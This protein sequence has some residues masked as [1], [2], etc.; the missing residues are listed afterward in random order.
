MPRKPK[1]EMTE[2]ELEALRTYYRE[3]QRKRKESLS[4]EEL[5]KKKEIVKQRNKEY[6]EKNNEVLKEKRKKYIAENKDKI[7]QDFKEWYNKN[8][9][10]RKEYAL[11]YR[12][13]NKEKINTDKK[14][15]RSTD[16]LYKLSENIRNLIRKAIKRKN[17]KK[18]SK[19]IDILGC[20]PIELQKHLE[21][22]FEPWMNWDNYGLYN[23]ELNYGWDIDHIIPNNTANNYDELVKLN[24]YTNLQ[25]LCSKINRDIKRYNP[26]YV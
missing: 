24:H 3:Y 21:N 20:T 17:H 19:T 12:E 18:Q 7:K 5:A 16:K 15:R 11:N 8:K 25:P 22:Q 14:E 4:E 9:D 6:K 1:S 10:K 2:E 13:N 23:G 26:N